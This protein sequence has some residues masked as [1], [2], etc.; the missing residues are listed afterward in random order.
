MREP[1]SYVLVFEKMPAGNY[2][3]VIE[4]KGFQKSITEL[5][6]SAS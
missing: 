4:V 2:E 5:E 1:E 3:I 6:L